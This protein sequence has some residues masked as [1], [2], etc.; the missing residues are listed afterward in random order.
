MRAFVGSSTHAVNRVPD[1]SL[2]TEEFQSLLHQKR[3]YY[4]P[5]Y[6]DKE[7]NIRY[8]NDDQFSPRKPGRSA[9]YFIKSKEKEKEIERETERE[10]EREGK[11]RPWGLLAKHLGNTTWTEGSLVPRVVANNSMRNQP[12]FADR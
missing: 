1:P 4:T 3:E 8:R 10:V 5:I 6:H 7:V 12:I 11:R 2:S 9:N